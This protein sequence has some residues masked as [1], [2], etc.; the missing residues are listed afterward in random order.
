LFGHVQGALPAAERCA[1][2]FEL[3]DGGAIFLDEVGSLPLGTQ[4]KLLRVLQQHEF[5]PVGGGRPTSVDVRV[6][7]ATSRDLA[8]EVAAGRFSAGLFHWLSAL[9]LIVP[10]LRERPGEIPQLLTF[11]LARFSREFGRKIQSVSPETM[12]LLV[13]YS[14]PGNIRE[15]QSIIGRAFLLSKGPILCLGPDLLPA[16][17]VAARAHAAP[18]LPALRRSAPAGS[19][20]SGSSDSGPPGSQPTS[21]KEVERQHILSVLQRASWV[22]E[23][24]Q[25]A[26][27][28]L[29]LHPN[30][31]RSRLK[32]LGIRRPSPEVT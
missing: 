21:V 13:T 5:E 25:G 10:P 23:G 6:I 22:I 29:G 26:A 18:A 19:G 20:V 30:T 28:L 32:K 3:A 12:E 15:M 8:K 9:T 4:I 31:L 1:A 24:P 7:A 11:L 17:P 16:S 14:W 27:K 2:G